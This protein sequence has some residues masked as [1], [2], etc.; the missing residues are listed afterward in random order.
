MRTIHRLLVLS[1][2]LNLVVCSWSIAD[3]KYPEKPIILI[4]PNPPG[5]TADLQARALVEAA[6]KFLPTPFIIVNRPGGGQAV[7]VFE[8][9]QAKP[10]GYTIGI[11]GPAAVLI[12]PLISKVPYQ[13]PE[14]VLPVIKL[15]RSPVVFIVQSQSPWKNIEEVITYAKANPGK[16]RVGTPG[17]GSIHHINLETLKEKA[18]VELTHVPFAGGAESSTALLGGHIE[19]VIIPPSVIAGHAKA[20]KVRVLGTFD[21]Q[22]HF[23]FPKTP[24][25]QEAG[26]DVTQ[27]THHFIYVPKGTPDPIVNN[28]YDILKKA[29]ET[30]FFKKFAEGNGYIVDG[31]GPAELTQ[32]MERDYPF[33]REVVRK[34]NLGK[35]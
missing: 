31:K 11:A 33:Y 4:V 35:K 6:K 15:S 19:A 18:R 2:L 24:T 22:R 23:M 5:G 25:F 26:Y 28:L 14:D 3:P 27:T 10:N 17:I 7:G 16:V 12:V 21:I 13:G 20:G 34:L 30:D 1:I 8:V 32:E 9:I 29:V